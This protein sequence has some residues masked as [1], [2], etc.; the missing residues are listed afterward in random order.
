MIAL[1][2]FGSACTGTL[3]ALSPTGG[4]SAPVVSGQ[5]VY[6]ASHDGHI[7][8]MNAKTGQV[9]T[10][11]TF[12]TTDKKWGVAYG[13]PDVTPTA[14]YGADYSCKGDACNAKVFAVDPSTGK[15]LWA[16]QSYDLPTEIVGGVIAYNNT[17]IF[18]TSKVGKDPTAGYLY[19][20]NATADAGK[21][22][23][24]QVTNRLEWRLPVG[25]RIWGRP[26]IANGIAYFGTSNHYLYAV[27]LANNVSGSVSN[28][29]LWR[30]KTK[31]AVMTQPTVV[32]NHVYFGDL[33]GN[34]YALNTDA[35]RADPQG[36]QLDSS[37]EWRFGAGAWFWAKPLVEGNVVYA[38]T[39]SG[40]VFAL[41]AN[42]GKPLW[43]KPGNVGGQVI[44]APIMVQSNSQK[45]LVVP[46][47]QQDVYLL[48]PQTG[49]SLGRFTTNASVKAT[50]SLGDS[51]VYV[52]TLDHKLEWFSVG[53]FSMRGCV[54][55]P[56]GKNCLG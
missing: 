50:P 32:G 5:W 7:V 27:S 33:A 54:E 9:D 49:A 30:F 40:T 55:L 35:R 21:A 51:V 31:G 47:G 14:I 4:W 45:A 18:G 36:Q 16:Q 8:R 46:S 24:T 42:T 3:V 6:V 12:P 23:S 28:R 34:F 22:S 29:I 44:G 41:D 25:G 38:G 20:L 17:L 13:T 26:A 2:A 10:S 19:A 1:L 15:S 53:D 37:R 11:W 56:A 48:N 39:L 43:Q 52:H